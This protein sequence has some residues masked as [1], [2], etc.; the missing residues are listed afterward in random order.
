MDEYGIGGL[1]AGS[2]KEIQRADRID[3]EIV[4]WPSG[5]EVMAGLGSSVDDEAGLT[6]STAF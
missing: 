6:C 4:E 1:L 5:C 3:V 2:F